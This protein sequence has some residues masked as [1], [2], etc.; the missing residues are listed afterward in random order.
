MSAV[1][2][3]RTPRC[4]RSRG[5]RRNSW[6]PGASPVSSVSNGS[7][8]ASTHLN[9][10]RLETF[11]GFVR[12][13]GIEPDAE[14][15]YDGDSPPAALRDLARRNGIHVRSFT[16]FQ[17]L[18]DLREYVTAQT[19]RLKSNSQYPPNLYL[20]Q[21]Y[22][23]AD[24]PSGLEH[25]DLVRDMLELLSSDH[26][27][28]LLLLGDFGHGKTF[29]LREIAQRIPEELPHLTPLFIDA[30]HPG[31]RAHPRRP[32]RRA[33]RRPRRRQHRSARFPLHAPPGPDRAALRRLR[34]TGQPGQLRPG[35]RPSGGASERRGGQCQD[36]REQPHPALQ[37]ARPGAHRARRAGR[38]AAA[39][40]G[41]GP[42]RPSPRTRSA[43]TWSTTTARTSAPPTTGC[44]CWKASPTCWRCAAIPVCSA[45]SPSSTGS[46]CGP[47]QAPDAR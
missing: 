8:C 20:P 45:S 19:E 5:H 25:D 42:G 27:R 30:E 15:I 1:P 21:R 13:A 23:E 12:A 37:V 3:I 35:G 47:S 10:R 22:R 29:A 26:G 43:A 24:G 2:A 9:P 36:R 18:L 31:P 38:P 40:P 41:A 44:G 6:S 28:F 34:R 46:G 11:I 4:G 39:A 33:P 32:G 17:G 14:L 16:D 7:P